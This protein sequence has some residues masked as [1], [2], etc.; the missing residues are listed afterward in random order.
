MSLMWYH[1]LTVMLNLLDFV[2]RILIFCSKF[3]GLWSPNFFVFFVFEIRNFYLLWN[4][5][6]ELDFFAL[7]IFSDFDF[8]LKVFRILKSEI[9]RCLKSEIFVFRDFYL[10]Y[11]SPYLFVTLSMVFNFFL[12]DMYF[13]FG[14]I[15]S[16]LIFRF[17]LYFVFLA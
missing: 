9:F 8:L 16:S 17:F 3:F 5:G 13:C 12:V 4:F 10:V 1:V 11:R 6:F 7:R 15:C 2:F 14:V